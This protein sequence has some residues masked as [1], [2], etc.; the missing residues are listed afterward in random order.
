MN[1]FITSI[2]AVIFS[3]SVLHAELHTAGY[4]AW[5]STSDSNY[6]NGVFE[7]Q[8]RYLDEICYFGEFRF[9]TNGLIHTASGGAIVIKPGSTWEWNAANPRVANFLNVRNKV[10]AVSPSTRVT[11]TIGGWENSQNFAT[12]STS[13]DPTG[14]KADYAA[15]QIR[16]IL[17]LSSG[18]IHGVDLDWED[19]DGVSSTMAGNE[20]S[21]VNL[22]SAIRDILTHGE[23]LTAAI[24]A[25]RYSS[26]LAILPY[27]DCLRPFTYDAPEYDSN[28]TSITAA[29]AIITA[30]INQG[31][32]SDKLGIGSGFY[33]RPLN[34]PWSNTDTYDSLDATSFANTGN[35]LSDSTTSY[36]GWGFEGADSIHAKATWANTLNLHTFFCWELKNDNVSTNLDASGRSH[37]LVLTRTLTESSVE[38]AAPISIQ[39]FTVDHS[40]NDIELKWISQM[41]ETYTIQSSPTLSEF[42]WIDSITGI[43]AADGNEMTYSFNDALMNGA[44]RRFWRVKRNP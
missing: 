2:F 26:G 12:F 41:G 22:V 38:S 19:G 30:W 35:W 6:L 5:W 7:N 31:A 39:N 18:L 36:L 27:I 13:N 40:S 37:Y 4:S 24:Q 20:S 43:E 34:N 33:A 1:K 9:D 44:D 32:P 3:S 21:Y 29:Q 23:S 16:A 17:D 14:I 25:T 42:D 8:V 11:F 15:E 10:S 28:H